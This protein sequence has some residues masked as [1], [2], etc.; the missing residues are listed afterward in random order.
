MI[1]IINK[2]HGYIVTSYVTCTY[3]STTEEEAG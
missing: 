3:T 1:G 2:L